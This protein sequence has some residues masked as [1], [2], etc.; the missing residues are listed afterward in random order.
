MDGIDLSIEGGRPQFYPEL[1]RELRRLMDLETRAANKRSYLI[2][3][4]PQC[5]Y[6]DHFLG[7]EGNGTGKNQH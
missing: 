6:P 4:A 7:P 5:R 1:I 2:T 3:A